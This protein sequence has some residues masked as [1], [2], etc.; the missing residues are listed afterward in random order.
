MAN[1]KAGGAERYGE[2]ILAELVRRGY[3]VTLFTAAFEGA[4]S[5]EVIN[6]IRVL[7]RGGTISLYREA[8][9]YLDQHAHEFDLVIDE[10]NTIP[11][12]TY[13]FPQI[14]DKRMVLIYQLAKNVWF[15]ETPL[16]VALVGYLIEPWLIR[17]YRHTKCV[18]TDS[19]S[20]KQDLIGLGFVPETIHAISPPCDYAVVSSLDQ[21]KKTDHLSLVYLGRLKNSKRVHHVI[22]CVTELK[23]DY[24]DV[25]LNIIGSGDRSYKKSLERLIRKSG[26]SQNVFFTGFVSEQEKVKYLQSAHFIL[27]A[28]VREGWG[29]IV[30]EANAQGTPAVVY[31]VHGLR[32]STRHN[33]TG[34]IT[35]RNTPQDLAQGVLTL[36]RD[37]AL[38]HRIQGQAWE[39]ARSL[40]IRKSTD[41]FEKIIKQVYA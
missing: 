16:P 14:E 19:D 38:Y 35:S 40:T 31:N 28:S 5:E 24:P 23:K 37:Q 20:T 25:R 12:R 33:E 36:Y 15:H 9:K 26:L 4:V 27:V 13:K 3:E 34:W 6:G 21:V 17:P 7:R 8:L 11:F 32:D 39:Y 18:I 30:N 29:L 22:Q 2:N 41:E 1:P 10:I